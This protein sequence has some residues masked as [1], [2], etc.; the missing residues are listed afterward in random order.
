M[1]LMLVPTLSNDGKS[2][3]A[4][5]FDNL[6]LRNAGV[7]LMLPLMSTLASYALKSH[8]ASCFNH[9][10]IANKTVLLT[11]PSVT[12]DVGTG[13][14]SI[15]G[16]KESCHTLFQLSFP[17]KTMVLLM[18]QLASCNSNDGTNDIT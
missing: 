3:V 11:V 4:S 14:N 15:T 5:P 9:L 6:E 1:M 2:H 7:L 10:D 13:V 17:N 8:V 18:M 12:F 16:P